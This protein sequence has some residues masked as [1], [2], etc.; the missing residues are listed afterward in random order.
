MRP[1]WVWIYGGVGGGG[2]RGGFEEGDRF[3]EEGVQEVQL[4]GYEGGRVPV[5]GPAGDV[6]AVEGLI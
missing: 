4:G 2:G 5:A 3:A 6:D 1:G